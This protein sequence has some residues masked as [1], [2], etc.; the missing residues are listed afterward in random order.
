MS[1]ND[2][3]MQRWPKACTAP[4]GYND[5]H[6]WAEAQHLHGLTQSN[7]KTCGRYR[8]PQEL[9]ALGTC[10]DQHDCLRFWKQFGKIKVR[11]G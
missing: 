9:N 8:F 7:C 6:E 10:A 3:I 1:R 5:W 2:E 4:A 11:K